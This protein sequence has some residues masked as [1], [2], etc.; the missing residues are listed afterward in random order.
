MDLIFTYLTQFGSDNKHTQRAKELDMK[1]FANFLEA[2]G[3]TIESATKI[4]VE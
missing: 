4:D 1:Q 3:K 2:I